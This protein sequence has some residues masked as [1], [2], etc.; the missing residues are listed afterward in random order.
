MHRS[1]F[2]K[3]Y[4]SFEKAQLQ[5]D[6]EGKVVHVLTDTG[7]SYFNFL[8]KCKWCVV[9][10]W[11]IAKAFLL[12]LPRCGKSISRHAGSNTTSNLV[13]HE[14]LCCPRENIQ[15]QQDMMNSFASGST[16]RREKLWTFIVRWVTGCRQPMSIVGDSNFRGLI[17][18]LNPQAIVPS[19]NTV[20]QDIKTMYSLTKVNLATIL[21]VCT[22]TIPLLY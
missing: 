9:I 14:R 20:T 10:L 12:I 2:A 21:Q 5:H 7:Q 3:C 18:M 6:A 4:T 19:Q 17:K 1:W 16:Y 8:F 22:F 15:L 11:L 13:K